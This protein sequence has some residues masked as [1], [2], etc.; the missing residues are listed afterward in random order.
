[1][2]DVAMARLRTYELLVEG[3]RSA[4]R[5]ESHS[6][7]EAALDGLFLA[8]S[9]DMCAV[10]Y[11]DGASQRGSPDGDGIYR[12]QL[13]VRAIVL[14]GSD[15]SGSGGGGGGGSGG[16]GGGG[17]RGVDAA[18][19][20]WTAY[21]QQQQQQ[22][23]QPAPS[24]SDAVAQH[25]GQAWEQSSL[26]ASDVLQLLHRCLGSRLLGPRVR[27]RAALIALTLLGYDAGCYG[28]LLGPTAAPTP[29]ALDA[30]RDILS[31]WKPPPSTATAVLR[32]R[33]Q[34]QQQRLFPAVFLPRPGDCGSAEL[35]AALR[36][37]TFEH[38]RAFGERT[39][40]LQTLLDA[41]F[42]PDTTTAMRLQ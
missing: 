23:Q 10:E 8:L 1:M 7:V 27:R 29:E 20:V 26:A 33:Q 36:A 13:A 17:A 5:T 3:V 2:H 40:V 34:Q 9:S 16:G 41:L 32:A 37:Q 19:A 42:Q 4:L 11:D 28:D 30:D 24:V 18:A 21:S 39:T 31:A 38:R 12:R 22:H 15:V 6:L 25:L 35:R 14:R